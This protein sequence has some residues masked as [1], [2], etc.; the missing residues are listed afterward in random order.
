M[1]V[2]FVS[3]YVFVFLLYYGDLRVM[4]CQKQAEPNSAPLKVEGLNV[5]LLGV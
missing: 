4:T 2:V 5:E 1:F 3:W